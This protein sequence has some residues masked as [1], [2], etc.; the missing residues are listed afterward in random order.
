MTNDQSLEGYLEVLRGPHKGQRWRITASK[1]LIGRS[2]ECGLQ[3]DDPRLSPRHCV[4]KRTGQKW[5]LVDLNTQSGTF[6]VVP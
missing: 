1:I 3:F 5:V 2:S 4:L 6:V